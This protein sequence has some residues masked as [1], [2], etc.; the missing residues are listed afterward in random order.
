MLGDAVVLCLQAR[1]DKSHIHNNTA[2]LSCSC[3]DYKDGLWKK[4]A[5]IFY[6]KL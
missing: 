4:Q 1:L 2:S 6:R 3:H 5:T